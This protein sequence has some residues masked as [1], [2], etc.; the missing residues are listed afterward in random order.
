MSLRDSAGFVRRRAVVEYKSV[1]LFTKEI[2][3]R[4]VSGIFAVHGN[5]DEG[6]DVSHPGLFGDF[7]VNGRRRARYLWQHDSFS[8]P[9]ATID[10]LQ[11]V[12]R[13]EL[14][15]AVL[16]YAP[17]ATGGVLVTRTYL[18][19]P[20]AE[21][22]F[23]G[24][25]SGAIDEMSYA[26]DPKRWD[27]AERADGSMFRNLY[28]AHLYDVSD[29]NWGMNPA[30]SAAGKAG[31]VADHH[32]TVLAAVADY[33]GRLKDLAALRAKE[34][35]VLS[36]ESRKRI[37]SAVEAMEQA[38]AALQELLAATDPGKTAPQDLAAAYAAYQRLEAQ[39]NGAL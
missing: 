4:T 30:T 7:A 25:K 34:G 36:G 31:K 19:T 5:L 6:R 33:T 15:G 14:P 2:T 3:G 22:V 10:A 29:V 28:E 38:R 32:T 35:R 27:F 37:E 21:E 8:P 39:L 16:A 17:D 18:E 11:E 23:A 9:T 20:R 13:A 12:P 24:L 1:P 26:Y